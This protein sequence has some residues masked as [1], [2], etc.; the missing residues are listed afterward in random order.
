MPTQRMVPP[1]GASH[2][3]S[4]WAEAHA[5]A[6]D[7]IMVRIQTDLPHTSVRRDIRACGELPSDLSQT[8]AVRPPASH[9]KPSRC[10]SSLRVLRGQGA[11]KHKR[12]YA[13]RRQALLAFRSLD[14]FRALRE[15]DR[16]ATG[17]R[18]RFPAPNKELAI[19]R[20]EPVDR[21]SPIQVRIR[22]P[23]AESQQTFENSSKRD[24]SCAPKSPAS[25][26]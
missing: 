17:R 11:A 4:P 1:P 5:D 13:A 24:R 26:A 18:T 7:C 8:G 22:L 3:S 2:G 19:N 10:S 12:H 25:R 20:K 23:P 14:P 16:Q 6:H 9:R 15:S 21:K